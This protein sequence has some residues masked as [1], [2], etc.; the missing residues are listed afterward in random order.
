MDNDQATRRQLAETE[1]R[2][3][4]L[5]EAAQRTCKA[6]GTSWSAGWSTMTAQRTSRFVGAR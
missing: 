5:T 2:L 6:S 3:A 1:A 4:R